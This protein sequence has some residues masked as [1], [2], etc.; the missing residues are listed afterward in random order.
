M[1]RAAALAAPAALA[2]AAVLLPF[3]LDWRAGRAVRPR[4]GLADTRAP[5]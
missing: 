3:A 1:R 2:V 5:V 4:G